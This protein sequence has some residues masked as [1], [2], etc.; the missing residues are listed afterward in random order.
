MRTGW[1][2]PEW[3]HSRHGRGRVLK[4]VPVSIPVVSSERFPSESPATTSL[5][6]VRSGQDRHTPG[7][8]SDISDEKR[9]LVAPYLALNDADSAHRS[10]DLRA[11]FKAMRYLVRTGVPWRWLPHEYPPWPAVYQQAQRWMRAG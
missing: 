8:P 11:V 4:D 5:G 3:G 7:N 9:A 10:H 1:G 2:Q 6:D